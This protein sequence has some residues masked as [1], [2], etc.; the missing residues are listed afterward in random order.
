VT[1]QALGCRIGAAKTGV[2]GVSLSCAV[3]ASRIAQRRRSRAPDV[4]SM[5]ASVRAISQVLAGKDTTS[6][7]SVLYAGLT[8]LVY[9][10]ARLFPA[11][12]DLTDA[13]Q[14]VAGVVLAGVLL[15]IT[16]A[17]PLGLTASSCSLCSE[18]YRRFRDRERLS[19]SEHPSF[20]S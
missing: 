7:R 3:R 6:R 17:L 13:G 11:V 20:S 2:A 8:L 5:E 1:V 19:V 15:W 12:S 9:L 10:A 16:E 14:A 18:R 4:R